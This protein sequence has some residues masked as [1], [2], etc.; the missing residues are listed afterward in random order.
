[1]HSDSNWQIEDV[2]MI[3]CF[4]LYNILKLS[5]YFL[6]RKERHAKRGRQNLDIYDPFLLAEICYGIGCGMAVLHLFCFFKTNSYLGPL[7]V[8]FRT[9]Y[10]VIKEY[11][12]LVTEWLR[13]WV[14]LGVMPPPS[15]WEV[16]GL[17]PPNGLSRIGFFYPVKK[18]QWL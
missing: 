13:W 10:T 9:K 4:W 15:G 12:S 11:Q 18:F 17:N 3:V 8:G 1:M 5:A 6:N 2:V 16:V 7:Q 14:I